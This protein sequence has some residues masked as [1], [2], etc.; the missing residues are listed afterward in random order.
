MV[1]K[2]Q[3]TI[4]TRLVR[5]IPIDGGSTTTAV[6]VGYTRTRV[7]YM[8]LTG[9]ESMH[10]LTLVLAKGLAVKDVET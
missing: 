7:I 10:R 2:G 4:T 8:R 3:E 6:Q 1:L 5:H 9:F